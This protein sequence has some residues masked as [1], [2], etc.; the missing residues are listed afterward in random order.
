M[1]PDEYCEEVVDGM[2]DFHGDIGLWFFFHDFDEFEEDEMVVLGFDEG[3]VEG[4][5][6]VFLGDDW[7]GSL[8]GR[9]VGFVLAGLAEG[10]EGLVFVYFSG[11]EVAEMDVALHLDGEVGEFLDDADFL[12]VLGVC[13]EVTELFVSWFNVQNVVR[14]DDQESA[15]G[16]DRP[17]G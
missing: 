13:P 15:S 11:F 5:V 4:V 10:V 8:A 7:V 1:V 16:V 6:L 14:G 3:L 2:E 12:V 9:V 17:L